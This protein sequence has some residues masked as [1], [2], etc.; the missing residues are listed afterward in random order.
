MGIFQPP[1]CHSRQKEDQEK[2]NLTWYIGIILLIFL[3]L[4]TVL[5]INYNIENVIFSLSG[6]T[7]AL[8]SLSILFFT[9]KH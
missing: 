5:Y 3:T 7:L 9:G 2:F 8:V 6:I 4:L 1:T